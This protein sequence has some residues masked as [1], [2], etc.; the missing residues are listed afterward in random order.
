MAGRRELVIPEAPFIVPYRLQRNVIPP[1]E[2][3][4]KEALFGCDR[5]IS[6]TGMLLF[7]AELW[8]NPGFDSPFF[9]SSAA[10]LPVAFPLFV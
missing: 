8:L 4:G 5:Y 7:L 6:L 3:A 1:Q 10:P 2:S 9:C